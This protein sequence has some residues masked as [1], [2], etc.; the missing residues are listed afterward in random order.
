VDDWAVLAGQLRTGGRHHGY[1]VIG[2]P[3]AGAERAAADQPLAEMLLNQVN[4][5]AELVEKNN[6]L[7]HQQLK[8]MSKSLGKEPSCVN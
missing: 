1:I 7:H 5:I 8:A 3:A 4:T 6:Q 2:L